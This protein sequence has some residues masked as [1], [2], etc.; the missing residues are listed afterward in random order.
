M[1]KVIWKFSID[2]QPYTEAEM[3]KGAEILTVQSQFNE[4]EIWALVD[5]EK[6]KETRRF[7]IIGTGHEIPDVV[8]RN[9]KKYIGTYQLDNGNF[10]F[11][12]FELEFELQRLP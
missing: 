2:T 12:V 4:P 11:H 10:V 5:P 3:P 9:F 6:E 8:S 1:S 7:A